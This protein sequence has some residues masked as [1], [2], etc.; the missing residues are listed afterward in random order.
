MESEANLQDI[1]MVSIIVDWKRELQPSKWALNW[2]HPPFSS[3]PIGDHFSVKL[4][5]LLNFS[6]CSSE[7]L[8]LLYWCDDPT[9]NVC[10]S[11]W[12]SCICN[13]IKAI[14]CLVAQLLIDRVCYSCIMPTTWGI[15]MCR[16]DWPFELFRQIKMQENTDHTIGSK[17]NN[18]TDK[19]FRQPA[20]VCCIL[21]INIIRAFRH[22]IKTI[23]WSECPI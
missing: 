20:I 13:E 18:T 1:S 12:E 17:N 14:R 22:E 21:D 19:V 8:A 11:T 9:F 15:E 6:L 10:C 4:R 16:N 3:L 7:L 5:F 2:P 23:N